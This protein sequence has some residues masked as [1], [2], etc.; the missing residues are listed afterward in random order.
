MNKP[1]D[2]AQTGLLRA[3]KSTG[4]ITAIALCAAFV[5]APAK[6]DSGFE[7]AHSLR[8]L[9]I[10]L[11]V[12]ALRCRGGP[13]DFQADYHQFA[14]AHSSHLSGAARTLRR[15]F[16]ASYGERKPE[17]ALDRMGVK[18]ANS[19]GDGHPWMDCAELKQTT[20]DLAQRSGAGEL[21]ESARYL[22]SASRP[23]YAQVQPRTA[24]AQ[25]E[26]A[27]IGYNMTADWEKRP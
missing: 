15:T 17:R 8:S 24:Y 2:T 13:D 14:A 12:T 9:D 11:M 21:A 18:I 26:G 19:Y 22:L 4:A 10:M 27:T 25:G 1:M 3:V 20:R 6:A 7:Q 5:S 23:Q 16:A